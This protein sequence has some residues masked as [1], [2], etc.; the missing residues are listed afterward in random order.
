MRYC[1]VEF[2]IVYGT[3]QVPQKA[4]PSRQYTVSRLLQKEAFEGKMMLA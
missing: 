2:K 1:L 4:F 3:K